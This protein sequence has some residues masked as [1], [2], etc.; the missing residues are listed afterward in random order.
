LNQNSSNAEFNKTI[1]TS[2]ITVSPPTTVTQERVKIGIVMESKV[3]NSG[4]V[5]DGL[6]MASSRTYAEQY[7][8]PFIREK[9]QLLSPSSDDHDAVD[10]NG[11][12][13]EIKASKV[14]HQTNNGK[15]NKT[16]IQRILFE[17]DHT[18]KPENRAV[19]FSQHNTADYLANIQN[20]KRDHFHLLVYVLLFLDCAKVFQTDVTHISKGKFKSWSDKHGRYDE[21][22]KSGQFAITKSTIQWH[23]DN[24][25]RDTVS[26]EEMTQIFEQLS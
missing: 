4:K 23:L 3:N 26:Y 9:Y 7:V 18:S 24:Y 12:R 20:V 1:Y 15:K 17:S 25:L 22:G 8:E 2:P 19:P 5:R 11:M 14:L 10:A 13:Y 16:I 6:F 21:K